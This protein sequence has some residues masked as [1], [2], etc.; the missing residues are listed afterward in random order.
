[1][2]DLGIVISK[3]LDFNSHCA[4]IVKKANCVSRQI[5]RC[6]KGHDNAFYVNLYTT[7]VRPIVESNTI[8]FSPF[9]IQNINLIESVQRNFTKYLPGLYDVAYSNRLAILQLQSL[10]ERRVI[11]DLIC[12]FKLYHNKIN[13]NINEYFEFRNNTFTRGHSLKIFKPFSRTNSQKYFWANRVIDVWN[14][15]PTDVINSDST[16]AF[17]CKLYKVDLSKYFKGTWYCVT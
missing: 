9:T 17:R 12:L 6:F 4:T 10:E 14:N 7:Y 8:I 13:L 1:M 3:H 2:R 16:D 15:L 5:K 11:N